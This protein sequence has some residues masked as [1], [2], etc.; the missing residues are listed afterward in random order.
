MLPFSFIKKGFGMAEIVTE[1]CEVHVAHVILQYEQMTKVVYLICDKGDN[2]FE[3]IVGMLSRWMS[4][5]DILIG[6]SEYNNGTLST[7]TVYG[8]EL[9]KT[10]RATIQDWYETEFTPLA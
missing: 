8:S 9:G 10:A 7:F 3:K 1:T 2:K 6:H 5:K 4:G